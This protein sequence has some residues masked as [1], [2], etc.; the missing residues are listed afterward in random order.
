MDKYEESGKFEK[1]EA[2][3]EGTEGGLEESLAGNIRNFI[4]SARIVYR[5][6]DY[7]SSAILYFKALFSILDFI[8]LKEKGFIPK[9]HGE[10]FRILEE[11]FPEHYR[12]LDKNFADYQKSYSS[13]VEKEVCDSIKEYVE[14]LAKEQEVLKDN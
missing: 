5:T 6:G 11:N 3:K 7:T 8:I 13:S 2:E 4:N 10:R 1:K 9:D 14:R 12:F